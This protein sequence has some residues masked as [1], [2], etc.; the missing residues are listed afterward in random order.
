[1]VLT[2]YR[3]VIWGRKPGG[4]KTGQLPMPEITSDVEF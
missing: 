3:R 1:M 2:F 4:P